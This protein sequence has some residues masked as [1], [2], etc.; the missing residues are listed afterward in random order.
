MEWESSS[1]LTLSDPDPSILTSSTSSP[2]SS[3]TSSPPS[4]TM[5]SIT[6]YFVPAG[7]DSSLACGTFN[8]LTLFLCDVSLELLL[9]RKLGLLASRSRDPDALFGLAGLAPFISLM[10][11]LAFCNQVT[12]IDELIALSVNLVP[13]VL[14]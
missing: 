13:V 9:P 2:G 11:S 14:W 6:T 12:F 10:R 7:A 5:H 3:V 1:V 8:V 4:M